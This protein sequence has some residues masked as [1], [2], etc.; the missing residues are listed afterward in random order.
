M[1]WKCVACDYYQLHASTRT[2]ATYIFGIEDQG[3]RCTLRT[4]PEKLP[5]VIYRGIFRETVQQLLDLVSELLLELQSRP[6]DTV[7]KR[8]WLVSVEVGY[9]CLDLLPRLPSI[10][11]RPFDEIRLGEVVVDQGRRGDKV[12]IEFGA[13]PLQALAMSMQT[14]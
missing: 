3:V 13:T 6:H 2:N 11:Q 7:L 4:T 5:S 9:D 14:E 10:L 1:N 8:Q 12:V